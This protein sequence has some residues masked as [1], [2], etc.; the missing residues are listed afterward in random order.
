MCL[1]RYIPWLRQWIAAEDFGFRVC[2]LD[3]MQARTPPNLVVHQILQSLTP[4][5]PALRPYLDVEPPNVNA[6][7]VVGDDDAWRNH[8]SDRVQRVLW[9]AMPAHTID[10]LRLKP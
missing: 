8:A 5:Y 6:N 4:R 7:L 3:S 1:R 10:F 2:W 9:D